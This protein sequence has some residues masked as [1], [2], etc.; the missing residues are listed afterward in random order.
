MLFDPAGSVVVASPPGQGAGYWAG[1]PG[2][3]FEEGR[4]YL[5]YRLRRPRPER[6]GELVIA[7]SEGGE[8][9]ETVWSAR[10]QDFGSAS[11][12]RC[13][14]VHAGDGLWRLYVA[15]VEGEDGPWVIDVQEADRP[16]CF[17][18]A[19]RRRALGPREAGVAA[20]KDPWLRRVGGEWWMFVSCASPVI[21]GPG[22]ATL[23]GDAL[24]TGRTNSVTGLATSADG[25]AWEW[26]GIVLDAS[27]GGWDRFTARLS[28]A[29]PYGDR[30]IGLYDGS[31]SL[32]ENYEERCGLA[33]S[34]DLLHWRRMSVLGP[35]I[36]AARPGPGAV[37][38]V[39]A[40]NGPGWTRYFFELTWPDGSHELR[41]TLTEQ[42]ST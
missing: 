16:D 1:A 13:A 8:R 23:A 2:A 22:D 11:I 19:R 29:V 10:R 24:S 32:D 7:T 9:F 37:R 14:L 4:F 12:E 34:S 21:Q 27:A 15:H 25:L 31:A 28:A 38:Y 18:P 42:A 36:G 5:T 3:T 30:W 41:T 33:L 35:A 17:D 6:G 26:R 40:V 20:V 39:E